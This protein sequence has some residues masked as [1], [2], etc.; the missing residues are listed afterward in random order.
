M[1]KRRFLENE[2]IAVNAHVAKNRSGG[3]GSVAFD[4]LPNCHHFGERGR[5]SPPDETQAEGQAE[6][7]EQTSDVPRGKAGSRPVKVKAS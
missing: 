7:A 3:V 2:G 1:T 6:E 4:F 5:V